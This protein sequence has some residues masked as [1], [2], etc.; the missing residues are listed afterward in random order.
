MRDRGGRARCRRWCSPNAG[1]WSSGR[2][3]RRTAERSTSDCAPAVVASRILAT[4]WEYGC[5]VSFVGRQSARCSS[6]S[7]MTR[8]VRASALIRR[9]PPAK[10]HIVA[11]E[12][13]FSHTPTAGSSSRTPRRATRTSRPLSTSTAHARRRRDRRHPG[14]K[15]GF[16]HRRECGQ[17]RAARRTLGS[18]PALGGEPTISGLHRVLRQRSQDS[19]RRRPCRGPAAS[20]RRP[21][22]RALR[23]SSV[24]GDPLLVTHRHVV[25]RDPARSAEEMSDRADAQVTRVEPA[26]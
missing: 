24:E 25:P 22:R 17:P 20:G 18:V 21:I 12:A 13:H 11:A 7:L 1:A 8:R 16:L 26:T 2:G 19:G 23:A 9:A 5:I 4:I 15:L 3:R 6:G 14:S 10:S